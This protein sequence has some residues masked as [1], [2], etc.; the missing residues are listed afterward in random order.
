M[1]ILLV[2]WLGPHAFTA[3][4]MGST[5]NKTKIRQTVW[6]GQK[7]FP[8]FKLYNLHTVKLYLLLYRSARFENEYYC[9]ATTVKIKNTPHHSPHPSYSFIVGTPLPGCQWPLIYSLSIQ[10]CLFQNGVTAVE[11]H[12][13]HPFE[14]K[15]SSLY[16]ECNLR[17]IHV[18]HINNLFLF[19][20]EQYSLYINMLQF[21]LSLT[22]TY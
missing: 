22:E 19:V 10:F 9:L 1:G 20:A 14:S 5:L 13:M 18:V 4:G 11:L 3:E 16:K 8:I 6:Y 15:L 2:Q 17:F 7:L 21:I 12:S